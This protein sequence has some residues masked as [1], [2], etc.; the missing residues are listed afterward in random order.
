[1]TKSTKDV[2]NDKVTLPF[3]PKAPASEY[4]AINGGKPVMLTPAQCRLILANHNEENRFIS[5]TQTNSIHRSIE[6]DKF[7]QDGQPITFNTNGHMT[8]K[9][10]TLKA[11]SKF[12]DKIMGEDN[13]Y[14]FIIVVGVE[15]D[16]FSKCHPAK[17]RT[18][19]DEVKRRAKQ[20]GDSCSDTE[21]N[22][23]SDICKRQGV[24]VEQHTIYSQWEKWKFAIRK[25]LDISDPFW[26]NTKDAYY[27]Q[28]K[29][30]LNAFC[31]FAYSEGIQ[32]LLETFLEYLANEFSTGENQSTTPLT[33]GFIKFFDE[34]TIHMHNVEKAALFFKML[35]HSLDKMLIREDAAIDF[36]TDPDFFTEDN[37]MQG[38]RYLK[39]K[40]I[41]PRR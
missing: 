1:M 11:V 33:A 20:D 28:S 8:E 6:R 34:N 30:T 4:G 13:T 36:P 3:N 21:Y 5:P 32:E 26:N 18:P 19:K 15:P 25:G 31:T 40:S 27:T 16:C 12:P 7:Y 39:Y 23:L 35:C 2:S 22:T 24:K 38:G 10:H 17:N 41:N 29:K 14:P 37:M 9:Q